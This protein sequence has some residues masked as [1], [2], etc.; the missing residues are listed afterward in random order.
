MNI[1]TSEQKERAEWT[2]F[3]EYEPAWQPFTICILD[4]ILFVGGCY[5]YL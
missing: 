1:W 2:E 5:T 4:G 3:V